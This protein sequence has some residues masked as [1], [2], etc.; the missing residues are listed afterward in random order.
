MLDCHESYPI[1]K[2]QDMYRVTEDFDE[3]LR[4]LE[5]Y[6]NS[7]LKP[8]TTTFNFEKKVIEYDRNIE[9]RDFGDEGPKF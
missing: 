9:C 1:Q 3:A 4:D 8:I 6:G 7:I 2:V 5:R